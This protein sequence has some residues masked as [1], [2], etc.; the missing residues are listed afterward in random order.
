MQTLLNSLILEQNR[1]L[2][3]VLKLTGR[4]DKN[5]EKFQAR[6]G[7]NWPQFGCLESPLRWTRETLKAD[8]K[9]L[10]S[11]W[12]KTIV[13]I[14]I[15]SPRP[16]KAGY[17]NFSWGPNNISSQEICQP[18]LGTTWGRSSLAYLL[19]YTHTHTYTPNP[20]PNP[21]PISQLCYAGSMT[22]KLSYL[23]LSYPL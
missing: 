10:E 7:G 16:R 18:S 11:A 12:P 6:L 5:L 3:L 17:L 1:R 4:M 22:I 13:A 23:I 2:A 19:A 14:W 9:W 20:D 8:G 21:P 15:S